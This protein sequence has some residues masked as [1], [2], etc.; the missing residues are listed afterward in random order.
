MP[1]LNTKSW[2]KYSMLKSK[3]KYLPCISVALLPFK[4]FFPPIPYFTTVKAP[5]ARYEKIIRALETLL[6][7]LDFMAI[8]CLV[9]RNWQSSDQEL[10]LIKVEL[11]TF[12]VFNLLKALFLACLIF[13][14]SLESLANESTL[15]SSTISHPA[16]D[17]S[18]I[19]I[20]LFLCLILHK[21]LLRT[22]EA[23]LMSS[24]NVAVR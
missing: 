3:H 8:M 16:K 15:H 18:V 5:V 21:M 2:F 11:F 1:R 23:S 17:I 9:I 13:L 19:F 4:A 6:I 20:N 12:F 14:V 7:V 24:F 10:G 22:S